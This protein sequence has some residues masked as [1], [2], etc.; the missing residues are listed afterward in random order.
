[1]NESVYRPFYIWLIF[2]LVIDKKCECSYVTFHFGSYTNVMLVA[3][4]ALVYIKRRYHGDAE[5][6]VL[7]DFLQVVNTVLYGY[8]SKY[9]IRI[10]RQFKSSS[11]LKY[12]IRARAQCK[13]NV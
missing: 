1:M 7:K 4:L 13:I 11:S 5:T 10:R 8:K 6:C 9:D 12:L 2:H 3:H